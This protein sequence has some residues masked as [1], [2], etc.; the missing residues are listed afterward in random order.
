MGQQYLFFIYFFLLVVAVGL[1]AVVGVVVSLFSY[2]F[3]PFSVESLFLPQT[4]VPVC[5][6][7]L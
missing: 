6:Y 7:V 5:E 1:I 4:L 2:S 3:L